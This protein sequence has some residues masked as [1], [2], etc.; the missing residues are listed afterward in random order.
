MASEPLHVLVN[1]RF[2]QIKRQRP[3][4][5]LTVVHVEAENFE[6]DVFETTDLENEPGVDDYESWLH[7][8]FGEIWQLTPLARHEVISVAVRVPHWD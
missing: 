1:D 5:L 4:W 6:I 7:L 2:R 8:A 3:P